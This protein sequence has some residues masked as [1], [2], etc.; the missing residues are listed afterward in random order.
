M[1][2]MK[3]IDDTE[4]SVGSHDFK[5]ASIEDIKYSKYKKSSASVMKLG[6]GNRNECTCSNRGNDISKTIGD[7][8][9]SSGYRHGRSPSQK[10]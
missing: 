7:R 10:L 2:M 1:K 9:E 8:K 5:N 4:Y 6:R 3:K